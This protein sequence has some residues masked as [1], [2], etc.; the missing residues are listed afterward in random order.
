[1]DASIA[2]RM[3]PAITWASVGGGARP[4]PEAKTLAERPADMTNTPDRTPR[5]GIVFHDLGDREP[6]GLVAANKGAV[7]EGEHHLAF[8]QEVVGRTLFAKASDERGLYRIVMVSTGPGYDSCSAEQ[9]S[10]AGH[11]LT[12]HW[13]KFLPNNRARRSRVG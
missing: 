1:M 4:E 9:R 8:A 2:I 6:V 12:D 5:A 11:F 13:M 10:I 7:V 3:V